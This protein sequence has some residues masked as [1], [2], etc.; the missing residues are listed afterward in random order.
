MPL[1]LLTKVSIGF[2][3]TSGVNHSHIFVYSIFVSNSQSSPGRN[4]STEYHVVVF[5]T[6]CFTVNACR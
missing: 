1:L 6:L 5:C 3:S 4:R 2:L